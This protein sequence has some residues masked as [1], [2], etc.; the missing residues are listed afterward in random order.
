MQIADIYV[1]QRKLRREGQ[2]SGMQESLEA[3]GC[4]P[5][6]VL[7]RGPDGRVQV[8]DGHH[9][10]V[11]IWMTGRRE[12]RKEEYLLVE[13]EAVRPR[14]GTVQDLLARCNMTRPDGEADVMPR[15]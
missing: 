5:R 7:S 8:E 3:G 6:I 2:L 12:L 10:L 15:F 1:S 13:K 14:F 4:L 11:A 9:R